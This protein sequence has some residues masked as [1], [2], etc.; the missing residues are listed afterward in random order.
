MYLIYS[1]SFWLMKEEINKIT[2]T[3]TNVVTLDLATLSL[4]EVLNEASYVSMF[5]EKKYIIVKNVSLFGTKKVDE[6]ELERFYEYMEHPSEMAVLLF[7]TYEKI[8][9]R[10]K[11]TKTFKEKYTIISVANLSTDELFKKMNQW[12]KKNKYT[13]FT[14]YLAQ[15]S[16]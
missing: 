5:P 7:T 4:E 8:D 2:G 6:K 14:I 3:N 16:K 13:I 12:I 9:L 1:D 15:L 10:K 11:I